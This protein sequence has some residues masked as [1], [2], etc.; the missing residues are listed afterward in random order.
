[1]QDSLGLSDNSKDCSKDSWGIFQL[2]Q[3]IPQGSDGFLQNFQ[4]SLTFL[5]L[6]K[7]SLEDYRGF[8][9]FL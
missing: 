3:M 9:R 5:W 6:S 2:F 7:D 1:M 8:L 4:D